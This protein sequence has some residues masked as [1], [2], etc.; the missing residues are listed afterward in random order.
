MYKDQTESSTQLITSE[1]YE[2][3]HVQT[4]AVHHEQLP[5]YEHS[6]RLQPLMRCG[7]TLNQVQHQWPHMMTEKLKQH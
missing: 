2:N 5:C 7:T 6:H 3:A 1:L 4:T